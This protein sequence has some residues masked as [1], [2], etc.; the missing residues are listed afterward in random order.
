M[1]AEYVALKY[2][3]ILFRY[4]SRLHIQQPN[5]LTLPKIRSPAKI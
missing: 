4:I 3:E 1:V 2:N 5:F